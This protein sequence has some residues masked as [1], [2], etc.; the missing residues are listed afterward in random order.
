MIWTLT[1]EQFGIYQYLPIFFGRR[2][3]AENAISSW[4]STKILAPFSHRALLHWYQSRL[5]V[6]A[7]EFWQN[8][9]CIFVLE[10]NS[11]VSQSCWAFGL[12]IKRAH[13]SISWS[14]KILINLA[15]ASI[16]CQFYGIFGF[17]IQKLLR[18]TPRVVQMFKG[19][20]NCKW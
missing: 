2:G 9:I 6:V 16:M 8:L 5:L 15:T 10:L 20:K 13:W 3:G 1:N 14:L 7:S 17:P 11:I 12:R 18:A 19:M 4:P